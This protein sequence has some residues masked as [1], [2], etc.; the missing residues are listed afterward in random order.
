MTATV[1]YFEPMVRRRKSV[2]LAENRRARFD[3]DI[4]EIYEAGIELLGHEVKSVKGGRM[5]LAGSYAAIREGSL[6]L[7]NAA[8]PPYQPK[9]VPPEYEPTRTRR[10][11]LRRDEIKK[12][13]GRL[14]EKGLTLVPLEAHVRRGL[15]KI[16]LGLCR[17]RKK[18]DKRELLKRR[19]AEREM[20]VPF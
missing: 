16:T 14:H 6:W 15:V 9:N 5:S 17:A 1:V 10:L 18:H 3:Y 20:R 8:V 11:L 12:L 2:F 19:T 7:M 13:T 4:L